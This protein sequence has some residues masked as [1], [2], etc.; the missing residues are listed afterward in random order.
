[1]QLGLS[2]GQKYFCRNLRKLKVFIITSLID[3]NSWSNARL[4]SLCTWQDNVKQCGP[5]T[6]ELKTS[7][8]NCLECMSLVSDMTCSKSNSI[9][10][11]VIAIQISLGVQISH[12]DKNIIF[13]PCRW[14]KH[15]KN[16]LLS[17]N[18][19]KQLFLYLTLFVN[20]V[21]YLHNQV[22]LKRR[23]VW[24][25]AERTTR[26]KVIQKPLTV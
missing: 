23:D 17:V 14:W 18:W 3:L 7:T 13:H 22:C 21:I 2:F 5:V 11:Q 15:G 8:V 6:T 4:V 1:M 10:M 20:Q 25:G 9:F 12:K 24:L 19:L 26:F 16:S